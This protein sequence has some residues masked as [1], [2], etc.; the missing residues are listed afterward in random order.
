[1]ALTST[2]KAYSTITF[3]SGVSTNLSY[4]V[5]SIDYNPDIGD[6]LQV[7]A[8]DTQLTSGFAINTTSKKIELN[9]ITSNAPTNIIIKRIANKTSRQI[10]FQ[11]ASV[12]TE[13]DLD[14]SALQTFH[15]AQEAIDKANDALPL[16]TAGTEWNA[17]ISSNAAKITNVA[18]PSAGTDAVNKTYADTVNDSVSAHRDDALDHRD[19][20]ESYATKINGVVQHFSA[21]SNNTSGSG[22]DQTGVYSSKEWAVGSHSGNT[23]G[24]SKQWALGGG[25]FANGTAVSGSDYSAK[26]HAIGTTVS[27]GSSKQWATKDTTAVASSLYSAKEYASGDA[28]TS[29]GSAKAWATDSSSPNGTTLKS[30]K[31][32]ADEASASAVSAQG[33][34]MAIALG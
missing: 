20:S 22:V 3:S 19:T 24:S 16:N 25:S 13:A 29:G 10:D 18:T 21:A 9:E 15:V 5:G 32:Y 6:Q 34:V 26:E 4:D 31:T 17:S 30:A 23:D 28:T 8:D 12:L 7:F 1:M 27:T 33:I 14:N 2:T 11:N